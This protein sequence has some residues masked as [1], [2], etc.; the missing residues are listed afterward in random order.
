MTEITIAQHVT[1]WKFAHTSGKELEEHREHLSELITNWWIAFSTHRNEI[2]GVIDKSCDFDITHFMSTSLQLIH[3]YLCWEFGPA[4]EK[5]GYR[6]VITPEHRKDLRPLVEEILRRAPAYDDWEFYTYRL[7][8]TYDQV[9]KTVRIRTGGSFEDMTFSG[10][11]NQYNEVDLTFYTHRCID[12]EAQNQCLND[13]YVGIETLLGEAKVDVWVGELFVEA[14]AKEDIQVLPVSQL[15]DWFENTLQDVI[16][17]LPDTPYFTFTNTSKW[18]LYELDPSQ[19]FDYYHQSDLFVAL[20]MNNMLWQ[21][22][23]SDFHFYSQR[24][25]KL[26]ETFCYLKL[27][28]DHRPDEERFEEKKILE[29]ILDQVLTTH[30]LGAVIGGGSGLTYSYID[31]ALTDVEQAVE[32]I[33]YEL[34]KRMIHKRSWILFFDADLQN[35]WIGIWDDSPAPLLRC[36]EE[37]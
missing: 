23:H 12:E 1:R 19:E 24:F 18:Y 25:S 37:G 28:G 3:P 36:Y 26:G 27:D 6:L 29:D 20:S 35:E 9:E 32:L 22:A 33:K 15:N 21:N 8:E 17:S 5:E 14:Q 31:F 4:I 13:A 30:E 7:P 10:V 11:V 2:I 34:R 16:K